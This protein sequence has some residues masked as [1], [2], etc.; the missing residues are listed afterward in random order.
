MSARL[1]Q[2]LPNNLMTIELELFL[3]FNVTNNQNFKEK[4]KR[5]ASKKYITCRP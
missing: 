3:K 4:Y 1:Q 5:Q 2:I